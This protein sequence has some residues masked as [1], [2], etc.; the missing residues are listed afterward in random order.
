MEGMSL[1]GSGKDSNTLKAVPETAHKALGSSF[2][3]FD[4]NNHFFYLTIRDLFF[5]V[6]C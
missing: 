3:D 1:S 6:K 5:T 4:K 2:F